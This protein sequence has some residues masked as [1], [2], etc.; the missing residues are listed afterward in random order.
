[1]ERLTFGLLA[2]LWL[3]SLAYAQGQTIDQLSAG[4]A[5]AG[6][7]SIPMF[8]GSNPAVTTTPKAIATYVP[9]QFASIDVTSQPGSDICAK[10]AN[11]ITALRA[12]S[13][14]GGTLDL[15]GFSRSNSS[16]YSCSSNPFGVFTN[17]QWDVFPVDVLMGQMTIQTDVRWTVPTR[18]LLHSAVASTSPQIGRG[19]VLQ[20]S[21][22]FPSFQVNATISNGSPAVVTF[23]TS[24]QVPADMW[25]EF[26]PSGDTLPSPLSFN[27]KYHLDNIAGRSNGTCAGGCTANLWFH[28]DNTGNCCVINTTTNGTGTHSMKSQEPVLQAGVDVSTGGGLDQFEVGIEN[29]QILC[30]APSGSTP[31]GAIGLLIQNAEENSHFRGINVFD[32]NDNAGIW[33]GPAMGSRNILEDWLVATSFGNPVTANYKCLMVGLNSGIAWPAGARP[34][35]S[36]LNGFNCYIND[37]VNN[38]NVTIPELVLIDDQQFF[39]ENGYFELNRSGSGS[40][41]VISIIDFGA[42][43]GPAFNSAN[44]GYRNLMVGGTGVSVTNGVHITHATGPVLLEA[45]QPGGTNVFVDNNFGRTDCTVPYGH[46]LYITSLIERA[47]GGGVSNRQGVWKV[48]SDCPNL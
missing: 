11:A 24:S 37:N 1:M 23:T 48:P 18:A 8:Q 31:A 38:Y 10:T 41:V 25:V 16:P 2:C 13:P 14:G 26:E 29:V 36:K 5:L 30:Q 39:V 47:D 6:T 27:E 7:E 4:S 15:R 43:W 34:K 33:M 17:N 19:F 44:V 20:A 32:C 21:N 46:D 3:P 9:T 12:M 35:M 40:T 45:M 28:S 22:N 42:Q